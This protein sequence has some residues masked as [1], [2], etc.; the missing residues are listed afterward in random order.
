[1]RD[2]HSLVRAKSILL[3]IIVLVNTLQIVTVPLQYP[4]PFVG[5]AR[6]G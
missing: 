4:L 5:R 2:C 1:M 6:E 3:F